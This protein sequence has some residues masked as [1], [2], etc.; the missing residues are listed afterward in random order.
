M[1]TLR[2]NLVLP[3]PQLLDKVLESARAFSLLSDFEDDVCLLA[4]DTAEGKKG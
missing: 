4:I 1:A 3:T 2:Q